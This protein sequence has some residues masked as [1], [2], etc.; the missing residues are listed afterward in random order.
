MTKKQN[1]RDR[2]VGKKRGVEISLIKTT[3][4]ILLVYIQEL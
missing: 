3:L 4:R 2:G 1:H